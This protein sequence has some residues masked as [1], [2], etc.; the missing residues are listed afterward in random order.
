M[1]F[2]ETEGEFGDDNF[3]VIAKGLF[4]LDIGTAGYTEYDPSDPELIKYLST[5]PE[6]LMMKKGH[7][8]SHNNM[9]VFF[10][11]TDN[12]ELVDNC[13]FHNF[14][15]SLI[16]NNRNEMCA[17]IAFKAKTVSENHV[18]IS[19]LNQ[20]GREKQ[21]KLV[22]NKEGECIYVYK[23]EVVKS[24]AVE[25]SFKGRFQELREA[26]ELKEKAKRLSETATKEKALQGFNVDD[27]WRQAGLFDDVK[28]S[29]T[30]S[31][32]K[33]SLREWGDGS[34]V[35]S[36][37]KG[38][39]VVERATKT[40]PKIYN[41]LSKL[42]SLDLSYEG[43]LSNVIKKLDR[44]FFPE[45]YTAPYQFH[46]YCDAIETRSAEFYIDAFPEDQRLL[47]YDATMERCAEILETYIDEYPEL[48]VSLIE[49]INS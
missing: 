44:E 31:K 3:K 23:C 29:T 19:Y 41:M 11:G 24:E 32:G 35:E 4:L 6:A 27:R 18:T 25:D 30:S 38:V 21:K 1:L 39:S 5:N 16:V 46:L 28:G 37:K 12:A 2:Y 7:I 36:G 9:G 48:M 8:H 42:L 15:V 34:T 26:K 40:D 45:E 13:G 10:S 33:T 49:V 20:E 47:N 22:T 43:V 17:K 14:Y